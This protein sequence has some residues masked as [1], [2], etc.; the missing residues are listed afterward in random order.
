[1]SKKNKIFIQIA[2]YRDPELVPTIKDCI[3]KAKYPDRLRF[4]ICWQHDETESLDKYQGD[5]RFS[6]IDCPWYESKGGGWA[7]HEIQKLYKGETYT[8]QLDSHHRFVRD[9]DEQL[10]EMMA[11]TGCKKPILTMYT[12]CFYQ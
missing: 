8:M 7:R 9:W 4:G 3:A 10:I 1:M 11:Q 5:E 2:S 6:I 12:I